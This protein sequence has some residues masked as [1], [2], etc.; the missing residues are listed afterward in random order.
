MHDLAARTIDSVRDPAVVRQINAQLFD[1]SSEPVLKPGMYLFATVH[2]A[3]N[4]DPQTLAAIVRL[5]DGVSSPS[6]PVVVALH[7]GTA[8]SL[9]DHGIALGANTRVTPPVGYRM[10][11]ALQLHAAAVLTD[12]AGIQREFAWLGTP[13]LVLRDRTEWVEIANAPDD[14]QFLVA[15]DL[16]KALDVLELVAP[17]REAAATATNLGGPDCAGI[18]W[19]GGTHHGD[20]RQRIGILIRRSRLSKLRSH[21]AQCPARRPRAVRL[22]TT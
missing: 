10:S 8:A 3:A 20:A 18:A 9:R 22:R 5:L 12:L 19:H 13:C 6:R 1:P 15:Q 16:D 14:A 21:L 11:L 4:R 2:R 7:P 17:L